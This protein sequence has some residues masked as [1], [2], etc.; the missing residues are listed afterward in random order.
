MATGVYLCRMGVGAGLGLGSTVTSGRPH[1]SFIGRFVFPS[2]PLNS[3]AVGRWVSNKCHVHSVCHSWAVSTNCHVH[4]VCVTARPQADGSAR[5]DS[6][7][8]VGGRGG[9]SR[10]W[11]HRLA[12][13]APV[14]G[15]QGPA[16]A[17]GQGYLPRRVHPP[18]ILAARGQAGQRGGALRTQRSPVRPEKP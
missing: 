11:A 8:G 15:P 2:S 6:W 7:R 17:L 13:L 14:P 9:A 10:L 5:V 12:Q 1:T 4:S 18:S 3:G 16:Q